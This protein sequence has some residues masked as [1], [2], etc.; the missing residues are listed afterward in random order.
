[1]DAKATGETDGKNTRIAH[2]LSN[3][4][5]HGRELLQ[6]AER[7][8]S[9]YAIGAIFSNKRTETSET[10]Y[11]SAFLAGYK[12][13]KVFTQEQRQVKKDQPKDAPFNEE[14]RANYEDIREEKKRPLWTRILRRASS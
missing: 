7:R 13:V 14:V 5:L 11:L 10:E 4:V 12:G 2:E 8:A 9:A 1:M 6:L 3:T